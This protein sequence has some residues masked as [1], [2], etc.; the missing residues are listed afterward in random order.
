MRPSA[1]EM[2]QER[3]LPSQ[4]LPWRCSSDRHHLAQCVI[5]T[6]R[7]RSETLIIESARKACGAKYDID[8]LQAS[9]AI[10]KN[11]RRCKFDT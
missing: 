1:P 9:I 3:F 11:G 8:V 5:D 2:R 10:E 7:K 4:E 6:N